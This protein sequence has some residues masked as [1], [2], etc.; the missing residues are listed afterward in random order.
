[1][2]VPRQ[3][4]HLNEAL[5]GI[6]IGVRCAS[7]ASVVNLLFLCHMELSFSYLALSFFSVSSTEGSPNMRWVTLIRPNGTPDSPAADERCLIPISSPI[8]LSFLIFFTKFLFDFCAL[9]HFH[10]VIKPTPHDKR[11]LFIFQVLAKSLNKHERN[12]YLTKKSNPNTSP[13]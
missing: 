6:Y 7:P 13:S 1:M 2:F 4:A 11:P 10:M 9:Q 8:M 3:A 12:S 5:G